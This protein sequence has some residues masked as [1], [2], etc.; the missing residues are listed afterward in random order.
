LYKNRQKTNTTAY[1]R[2]FLCQKTAGPDTNDW[3]RHTFKGVI[4]VTIY[5]QDD[6][7]TLYHGDCLTE[8]RE[9]LEADVLVTDPPY[10]YG[11]TSGRQGA[12]QGE[13]IANDHDLTARDSVLKAWGN[14]P[15]LVFGSW[16]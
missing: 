14:K 13:A 10:G 3:S 11:H 6:H 9:W 2:S 15:A 4:F 5:Y 1:G 8:H 7:V 12:F 16:K